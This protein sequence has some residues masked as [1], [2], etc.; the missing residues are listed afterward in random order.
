[1]DLRRMILVR[2][3]P[4]DVAMLLLVCKTWSENVLLLKALLAAANKKMQDQVPRLLPRPVHTYENFCNY[5]HA[6][7]APLGDDG[8]D[9][10]PENV[11]GPWLPNGSRKPRCMNCLAQWGSPGPHGGSV[12]RGDPY[13]AIPM[14]YGDGALYSSDEEQ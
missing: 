9:G 4:A 8:Y 3:T 2:W 6:G 13:V 12:R 11:D 10:E 14:Y 1:M 5:C 7:Q